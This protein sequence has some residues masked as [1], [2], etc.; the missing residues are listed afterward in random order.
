M[1]GSWESLGQSSLQR[2][3]ARLGS[4][5]GLSASGVSY[6]LTA[7]MGTPQEL[8]PAEGEKMIQ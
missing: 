6:G 5:I 1:S 7:G 8:A 3:Q 2:H 4:G